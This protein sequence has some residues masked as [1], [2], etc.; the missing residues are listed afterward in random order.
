MI[1][2]SFLAE[3]LRATSRLCVRDSIYSSVQ[4]TLSHYFL[5]NVEPE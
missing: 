1:R 2:I 5:A 4:S 3:E